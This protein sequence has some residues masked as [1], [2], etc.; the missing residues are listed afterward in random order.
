[1]S[2]E[3]F[4]TGRNAGSRRQ[5]HSD[6]VAAGIFRINTNVATYK[7]LVNTLGTPRDDHGLRE[8]NT[9]D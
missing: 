8:K 2:F 6:T 3:D 7:R 4:E 5:D 1:M 9:C